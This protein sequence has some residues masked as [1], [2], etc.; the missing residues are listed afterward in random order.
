[1]ERGIAHRKQFESNIADVD[2]WLKKTEFE[3]AQPL[4]LD[5]ETATVTMT[6][7]KYEVCQNFPVVSSSNTD[8]YLI[9]KTS[10][11]IIFNSPIAVILVRKIPIIQSC[12]NTF[13]ISVLILQVLR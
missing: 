10:Q 5:A 7:N 1:M 3:L 8:S 4:K 2:C 9:R 12:C 13:L 6:M 11:I